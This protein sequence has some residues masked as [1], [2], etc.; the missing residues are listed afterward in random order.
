MDNKEF[1]AL[2]R[3][4]NIKYREIFEDIPRI[5]DYSCTREEYLQAMEISISSKIPVSMLLVRHERRQ[6]GYSV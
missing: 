5:T 2:V 6:S 3:P 1:N 4:L